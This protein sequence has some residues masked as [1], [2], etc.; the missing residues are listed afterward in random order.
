MLNIVLEL[1]DISN[2][3]RHDRSG[4][5]DTFQ[6]SLL[7]LG[8]NFL[9]CSVLH[10]LF[11]TGYDAGPPSD[12]LETL[13]PSSSLRCAKFRTKF[14]CLAFHHFYLDQLLTFLHYVMGFVDFDPTCAIKTSS[15][16]SHLYWETSGYENSY[17]YS[18]VSITI[19]VT[20]AFFCPYVLFSLIISLVFKRPSSASTIHC[21]TI[22]LSCIRWPLKLCN[23]FL[24][25]I[26]VT[27]V[28]AFLSILY[29]KHLE[30]HYLSS[31]KLRKVCS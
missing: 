6:L 13:F 30:L 7:D 23:E 2:N 31:S 9:T 1:P 29:E 14:L 16:T 27:C 11:I 5:N 4:L 19:N 10:L 20:C 26:Y 25:F 24:L 28:T 3:V 21:S 18:N 8:K 12:L 17:F 22:F 15:S